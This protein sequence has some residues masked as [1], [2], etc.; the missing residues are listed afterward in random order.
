MQILDEIPIGGGVI[1]A[2]R[3][4]EDS[5]ADGN[6]QKLEINSENLCNTLTTVTKDCLLLVKEKSKKGFAEY[7]FRIRR[8]TPHEYGRFMGVSESDIEKMQS[9]NSETQLYKQYGNSIAVP[10]LEAIF[11]NLNISGVDTWDEVQKKERRRK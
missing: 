5:S 1:V 2:I 10:C 9:V 8:L 7:K 11:R 6:R 4:R 3:G